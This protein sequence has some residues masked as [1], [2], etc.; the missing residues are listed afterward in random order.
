MGSMG[1]AST[2]SEATRSE[3]EAGL[4]R[5]PEDRPHLRHLRQWCDD[6]A[7]RCGAVAIVLAVGSS[8]YL[9]VASRQRLLP[10][11]LRWLL[12]GLALG[13]LALLLVGELQRRRREEVRWGAG[14]SQLRDELPRVLFWPLAYVV[15]HTWQVLTLGLLVAAGALE[16]GV[17]VAVVVGAVMILTALMALTHRLQTKAR[18]CPLCW[19][20]A[21]SLAMVIG[22]DVL[23]RADDWW[24]Y[25]GAGF[26]VIGLTAVKVALYPLLDKFG[27]ARGVLAPAA[28][29]VR[30]W[31][32]RALV[33]VLAGVGLT[34]GG[35]I[36]AGWAAAN[37]AGDR[38]AFGVV[39]AY[40]GFSLT[41][42]AGTRVRFGPNAQSK[43]D[44]VVAWGALV[45]G[46]AAIAWG[47]AGILAVVGDW[48]AMAA[49]VVVVVAATGAWFVFRGEGLIVLGLAVFVVV[50]ALHDRSTQDLVEFN[51]RETRGGLL[52]LGDSFMSGEGAADFFAG[53]NDPAT[54]QCRRAATSYAALLADEHDLALH[55]FACSGATMAD[56]TTEGQMPGSPSALVGSEGQLES[57]EPGAGFLSAQEHADLEVVLVS[58]GGN[59]TGFS[60]IIQSCLLPADCSEKAEEWVAKAESLEGRL[61]DTYR[62]IDEATGDAVVVVVPYPDYIEPRDCDRVAS[63]VEFEFV[64][65]FVGALNQTIHRAA[66]AA[67][68]GGSRVLVADG[69]GVFEGRTQCAKNPPGPAAN[70]VVLAPPSGDLATRLNPANWVH[71]TMHPF[72]DGHRLQAE[73]LSD[74]IGDLVGCDGS[75]HCRQVCP[76]E[77]EQAGS[78]TESGADADAD[79]DT[80]VDRAV[81]AGRLV[82]LCADHPAQTDPARRAA[83]VADADRLLN[84][85]AWV[86]GALWAAARDLVWPLAAVVAGGMV[87]ALGLVRFQGRRGNPIIWLMGVVAGFLA[88][89]GP[90]LPRPGSHRDVHLVALNATRTEAV[91]L[92]VVAD[93]QDPGE[94][95]V[96]IT[97]ERVDQGQ[98]FARSV[99]FDGWQFVP[100]GRHPF[101]WAK[102]PVDGLSPGTAYRITTRGA[103]RGPSARLVTQPEAG[104]QVSFVVGS[105][106]D[107]NNQVA[108]GLP[109]AYQRLVGDDDVLNLWLG[110]QIYLDAPW[111]AGLRQ[112]DLH[113]LVA[114]R[115]LDSWEIGTGA[116]EGPAW[117]GLAGGSDP[118]DRVIARDPQAR[119]GALLRGSS[120][121]F[122]ADDHEFWNGYPALSYGTLLRHALE[123]RQAHKK[124]MGEAR[125]L[126][127]QATTG[128]TD[129]TGG[130]G[131]TEGVV[132]P[133][134]AGESHPRRQG[135]LGGLAG[136]G[137]AIFQTALLRSAA[138]AD[139]APVGAPDAARPEGDGESGG[140]LPLWLS[141][142]VSP[143]AIETIHLGADGD[144][145]GPR[146]LL[147]DTRW[148]RTIQRRGPG[149]GFMRQADLD[150]LVAEL[151]N[152][153][154]EALVMLV[155]GRPVIGYAPNDSLKVIDPG[156]EAYPDQYRM[157]CRAIAD[158][159]LRAPTVV[160][161]G[162]VHYHQIA[163][164]L[165]GRLLEIVSS[166]S[167]ILLATTGLGKRLIGLFTGKHK[168]NTAFADP[169]RDF[170][171]PDQ[172]RWLKGKLQR[173]AKGLRKQEEEGVDRLIH[174][175]EVL[176]LGRDASGLVRVDLCFEGS[177]APTICYRFEA[178]TAGGVPK[179]Q[180]YEM[181]WEGGRWIVGDRS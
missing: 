100:G 70:L 164:A 5:Q 32:M 170:R 138:A 180:S 27:V 7:L 50:W 98:P 178:V 40:I 44:Q 151:G 22:L 174:P 179:H 9:L 118:E 79:A 97:P 113:D 140:D 156:T 3:D 109:G 120:N 136:Q 94:V 8:W 72:A 159:A 62:Q 33:V 143:P 63:G 55:H 112:A 105:C 83:L 127:R 166:P 38:L 122:L 157:L 104:A 177:A 31:R 176:E 147:V 161:A 69:T 95:E 49:V 30:A 84:D 87:G 11:A 51:D 80:V 48:K 58:I 60:S 16:A 126:G 115:Y 24:R 90:V 134:T 47:A 54:N 15:D 165:D 88:P 124:R 26:S 61:A 78:S 37:Q 108:D 130:S 81:E 25:V 64:A 119:F 76:P 39:L 71:G 167:S 144:D 86:I 155:L 132:I 66:A 154:D 106:Y 75:D 181:R 92:A 42:V 128:E 158:R 152:P 74:L 67:N 28:D 163:T 133:L 111:T 137:Y 20:G 17:A 85:D 107:R 13:L 148:Y 129:G 52:A 102:V 110:D 14:P 43:V 12:A 99:I 93:D 89:S 36:L 96:S 117:S 73:R 2:R 175:G 173:L 77:G 57:L 145:P 46:A 4:T 125:A 160:V 172:P 150:R 162:D 171:W 114:K 18:V 23:V 35:L 59:D 169:A 68:A 56:V 116:A 91:L 21:G 45:I 6:N 82:D 142:E 123:R 1:S 131:E 121:R 103:A 34:V 53:T 41:G 135:A 101:H 139:P 10:G 141:E 168:P 19:V 153:D 146:V 149:A 65:G 29:T